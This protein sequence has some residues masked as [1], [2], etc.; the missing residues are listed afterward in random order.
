VALRIFVRNVGGRSWLGFHFKQDEVVFG[1]DPRREIVHAGIHTGPHSAARGHLSI[2]RTADRITVGNSRTGDVW[3]LDATHALASH[4][5][6][7]LD[8]EFGAPIVGRDE[9]FT[10][11]VLD[12]EFRFCVSSATPCW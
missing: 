12:W 5:Y 6:Q 1:R 10:C 11:T 4:Q 7:S 8:G 3:D 9:P 2:K